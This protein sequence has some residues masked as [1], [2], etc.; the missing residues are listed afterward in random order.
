[1]VFEPKDYAGTEVEVIWTYVRSTG[2]RRLRTTRRL[3]ASGE[4]TV[5]ILDYSMME[6]DFAVEGDTGAEA[7]GEGGEGVAFGTGEHHGFNFGL[8]AIGWGTA[9][10]A[11]FIIVRPLHHCWKNRGCNLNNF[12]PLSYKLDMRSEKAYNRIVRT[13][14]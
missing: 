10:I 9:L 2:G 8:V 1:V 7:G 6:G 14:Y 5:R 13:E 4:G 12:K 3:S 11:Y